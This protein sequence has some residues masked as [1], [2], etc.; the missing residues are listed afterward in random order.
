MKPA[1][2]IVAVLVGTVASVMIANARG[3]CSTGD[4]KSCRACCAS[5]P[6]VTNRELC[7]YQCGESTCF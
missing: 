2:S 6:A 3:V 7:T 4:S 5:H 1:L